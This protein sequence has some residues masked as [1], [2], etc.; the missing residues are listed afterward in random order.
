MAGIPFTLS[1]MTNTTERIAARVRGIAAEKRF[2]QERIANTLGI[3][4]SSVVERYAGR[5]PFSATEVL[6]LAEAMNEPVS[7]FFPREAP[8]DVAA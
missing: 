6:I 8:A 2:T 4:R 5:V 3:S 1:G 7:R